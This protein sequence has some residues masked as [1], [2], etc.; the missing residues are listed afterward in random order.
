MVDDDEY[1]RCSIAA[2]SDG[3]DPPHGIVDSSD[4]EC[5]DAEEEHEDPEEDVEVLEENTMGWLLWMVTTMVFT[6]TGIV[7]KVF[8]TTTTL[9]TDVAKVFWWMLRTITTTTT[10][11]FTPVTKVFMWIV[12]DD[13]MQEDLCPIGFVND[14]KGFAHKVKRKIA[15][16]TRIKRGFTVDSGAADDDTTLSVTLLVEQQAIRSTIVESIPS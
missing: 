12:E 2:S 6:T 8:P 4:S 13:L 7:T 9:F 11:L 1:E 3:G 15:G 16:M 14:N 5:G 10:T